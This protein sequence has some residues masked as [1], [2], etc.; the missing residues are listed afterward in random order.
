M[1]AQE[2]STNDV[3]R[4]NLMDESIRFVRS[5]API[6]YKHQEDTEGLIDLNTEIG[7]LLWEASLYYTG[8][9]SREIQRNPH[10][11]VNSILSAISVSFNP[12]TAAETAPGGGNSSL[13]SNASSSATR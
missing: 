1:Q 4:K 3:E 2:A 12:E 9:L 6:W 8:H 5:I 7:S 11:D 13:V 10:V